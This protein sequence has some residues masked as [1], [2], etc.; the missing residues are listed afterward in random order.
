MINKSKLIVKDLRAR[1]ETLENRTD[2][3]AGGPRRQAARRLALR[4]HAQGGEHVSDASDL[5]R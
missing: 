1:K 5:P 2:S 3:S 4:L